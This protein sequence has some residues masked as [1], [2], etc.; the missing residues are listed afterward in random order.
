MLTRIA[1]YRVPP[2]FG[3]YVQDRLAQAVADAERMAAEAK[4]D[5]TKAWTVGREGAFVITIAEDAK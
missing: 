2:G 1:E 5:A 4:A 3:P